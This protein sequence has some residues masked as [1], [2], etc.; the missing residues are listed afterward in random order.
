MYKNIFTLGLILT[1]IY[2]ATA[3]ATDNWPEL[4]TKKA[5]DV[6]ED[7]KQKI[8]ATLYCADC[9]KQVCWL[10]ARTYY[11]NRGKFTEECDEESMEKKKPTCDK[12]SAYEIWNGFCVPASCEKGY[13]YDSHIC[14]P[15]NNGVYCEEGK[16]MQT[17][18]NAPENAHYTDEIATSSDC[19]WECNE[20]Y[21]QEGTACSKNKYI[22]K[23]DANGGTGTI[24]PMT[25]T[26]GT[27]NQL[28]WCVNYFEKSGSKC[29]GWGTKKQSGESEEIEQLYADGASTTISKVKCEN[30]IFTV[31]WGNTTKD[32]YGADCGDTNSFTLY[33]IWQCSEGY[34]QSKTDPTQC[35]PKEDYDKQCDSGTYDIGLEWCVDPKTPGEYSETESS[36]ERYT[37]N[38]GWFNFIGKST[39]SASKDEVC[40][41]DSDYKEPMCY[42]AD[43][44][45]YLN[46][47]DE[48]YCHCKMIEPRESEWIYLEQENSYLNCSPKCAEQCAEAVRNNKDM[49]TKMYTH[50]ATTKK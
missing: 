43:Y 5:E 7:S 1:S 25:F 27:G 24:D 9:C 37:V 50:L 2:T 22:V 31:N 17:C 29:V 42:Y 18:H 46:F 28:P 39:C 34:E 21:H 16:P 4:A 26:H 49:R 40:Y 6:Y 38:F 3:I 35:I 8:P 20:G 13:Y 14:L 10:P 45:E 33:A 41:I 11:D 32:I 19:P 36:L 48:V 23:F 12:G 30:D 47:D 15:C 44:E